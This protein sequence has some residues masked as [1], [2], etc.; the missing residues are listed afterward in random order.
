MYMKM[1]MLTFYRMPVPPRLSFE[2]LLGF[3]VLSLQLLYALIVIIDS[4][5][6]DF[7]GPLLTNDK[8]IEVLLQS[9]GSDLGSA[10]VRGFPQ[11]A[12]GR[13]AWLIVACEAVAGKAGAE[14]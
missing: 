5:A 1:R 10:N 4:N 8:M 11:R 14:A 9:S 13:A 7:L 6:Q 3:I 12:F 2:Y